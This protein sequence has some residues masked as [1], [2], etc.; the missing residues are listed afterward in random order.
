MTLNF[1]PEKKVVF[2]FKKPKCQ[3]A[4][5]RVVSACLRSLLRPKKG[6]EKLLFQELLEEDLTR[7]CQTF[8]FILQLGV[9]Y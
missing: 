5:V 2:Q 4:E 6:T 8:F 1:L 7:C 3:T 9:K